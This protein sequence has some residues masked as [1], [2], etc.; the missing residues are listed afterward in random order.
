MA[1][2][3]CKKNE[4]SNLASDGVELGRNA[5]CEVRSLP[6]GDAGFDEGA[7]PAGGPVAPA[8]LGGARLHGH[9]A[10]GRVRP[11]HP[12]QTLAPAQRDLLGRSHRHFHPG[13]ARACS[14]LHVA[15]VCRALLQPKRR[16]VQ[17][18][19]YN[20]AAPQGPVDNYSNFY[21]E[22]IILVKY[23]SIRSFFRDMCHLRVFI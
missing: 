20:Y 22:I 8:L 13:R 1:Y 21:S 19:R 10:G 5:F 4:S 2:R 3:S 15:R 14:T 11:L 12:Q 18:T 7:H 9:L 6:A 16:F 17:S 23:G